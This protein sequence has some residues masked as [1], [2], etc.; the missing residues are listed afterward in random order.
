MT[1]EMPKRVVSVTV[2][3]ADGNATV[4]MK[5][6][7]KRKGQLAVLRPL[8][9]AVRRSIEGVRAGANDY[10]AKHARSNSEQSEGWI[11]DLGQNVFKATRRAVTKTIRGSSE[12]VKRKP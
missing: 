10:L 8:E 2:I 7:K 9:L 4:L 11:Q 12:N 3:D 5:R 6:K 1:T